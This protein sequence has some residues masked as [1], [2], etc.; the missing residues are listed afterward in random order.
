M[1]C[2]HYADDTTAFM[3]GDDI[4]NLVGSVDSERG[5]LDKWLMSNRLSLN[6]GKTKFM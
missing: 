5:C 4:S 6:V 1:K 3:S 2:V